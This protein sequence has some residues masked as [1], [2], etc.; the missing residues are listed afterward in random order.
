LGAGAEL[1]EAAA[2]SGP[3]LDNDTG[4]EV[5]AAAW[6]AGPGGARER[7]AAGRYLGVERGPDGRWSA[8]VLVAAPLPTPPPS[9][10]AIAT[11]AA[12]G[13]AEGL[14]G[15][16]RKLRLGSFETAAAAARAYDAVARVLL[17]PACA[18]NFPPPPKLPPP[19]VR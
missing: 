12:S 15:R 19:P 1:V 11:A 13:A 9:P 10:G 2:E 5:L 4:A 8:H 16:R 3:Q 6:S 17:G 18:T 7:P 14:D